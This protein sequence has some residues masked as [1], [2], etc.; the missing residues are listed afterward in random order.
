M[1]A[2]FS[3]FPVLWAKE[4]T[5]PTKV[6]VLNVVE[7]IIFIESALASACDRPMLD[8]ERI[9]EDMWHALRKHRGGS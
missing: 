8:A 3:F 2:G 7:W 5:K 4:G 6:S 9:S 1:V